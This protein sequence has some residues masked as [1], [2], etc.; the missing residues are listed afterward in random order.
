MRSAP[1]RGLSPS[2]ARAPR[3]RPPGPQPWSLPVAREAPVAASSSA[4]ADFNARSDSI[5][6]D[7]A[8]SAAV[9]ARRSASSRRRG[10][11]LP[12]GGLGPERLPS[13]ARGVSHAPDQP[14]AERAQALA[15]AASPALRAA[16]PADAAQRGERGEPGRVRIFLQAAAHA[17]AA[18]LPCAPIASS[19]V[20]SRSASAGLSG[21]PLQRHGPTRERARASSACVRSVAASPPPGRLPSSA[22]LSA[23]RT[24]SAALQKGLEPCRRAPQ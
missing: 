4:A 15:P 11:I 22:A 19:V 24:R 20:R 2:R 5:R 23:A 17:A 8:R 12:A 21:V 16:G 6:R 14:L 1:E 10:G 18:A 7:S 13:F 3:P 9:R